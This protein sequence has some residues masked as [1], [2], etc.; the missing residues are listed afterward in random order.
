MRKSSAFDV[1]IIG[2]SYAGLSAAMSLG[3]SLRK[4]LVIDAGLPCNRQTP[5]SQNFLTQD[6]KAPAEISKTA[7]QQLER[8]ETVHFH[9]GSAQ[10]GKKTEDGFLISTESGEEF[11]G[12]KL[13]FATGI[14]DQMPE[15]PGFAATWGISVIHCPYC[16]GFEHRGRKTGILANGE[17]AI[18][19][20]PL[21]KNLTGDLT[22]LTNGEADFSPEQFQKFQ[23]HGIA[24]LEMEIEEIRHQRGRLEKV[25]LKDGLELALEAMYAS[26]PFVQHTDIPAA[27]GCEHTEE[28]F[29]KVD[30]FQKT[31]IP[32]VYACGDNSNPL[33]SVALAVAAGNIAGAAL[34]MEMTGE[35]F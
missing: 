5:H 7:R 22:I 16:H 34:N 25:V 4:T 9:A 17:A 32:G 6:G 35:S 1:I 29:L 26:I 33:R 27:L 8:Y 18:H 20:A 24:V 15:I 14:K 12:R 2:G 21:V 31:S 23:S 10:S 28:G 19:L 30:P 11:E 13:I 3:R